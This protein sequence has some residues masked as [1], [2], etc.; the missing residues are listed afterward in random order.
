MS[1][2]KGT[3]TWAILLCWSM[4][5]RAHGPPLPPTLPAAESRSQEGRNGTSAAKAV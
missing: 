4:G 2:V 3:K 5:S 1:S